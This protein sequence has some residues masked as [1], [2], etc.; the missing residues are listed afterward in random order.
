[1]KL[2][3]IGDV[4]RRSGVPPSSLRY[5]EEL[6][7][8]TSLGRHGLRRQFGPE[9]L[10]RLSL[11]SLGKA[12]GFALSEIAGVFAPSGVPDLPR[13]DLRA[14][15]TALDRQARDLTALAD[16]LRHV[17]DCPASSHLDCPSFQRLMRVANQRRTAGKV[18]PER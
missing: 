15:A 2:L 11:I 12:A 3:D 18:L 16:M 7:L 14:R 17:A 6:G 9:T 10:T 4:S 5:Y 8:I 1:M 13:D